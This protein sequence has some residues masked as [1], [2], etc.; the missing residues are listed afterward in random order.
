M[1]H[2]LAAVAPLLVAVRAA[3]RAAE[4]A[5]YKFEDE[6]SALFVAAQN[7]VSKV[8]EQPGQTELHSCVIAHNGNRQLEFFVTGKTVWRGFFSTSTCSYL[9]GDVHGGDL[10]SQWSLGQLSREA[11]AVVAKHDAR[12]REWG[13][14]LIELAGIFRE[15]Q[16]LECRLVA[17]N[18]C[19]GS[20]TN[21]TVP[22][23]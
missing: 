2:G 8:R 11:A 23:R 18:D 15:L 5:K 20:T 13:R 16:K 22:D 17:W 9:R 6:Q 19:V 21:L 10:S 12:C 14:K 1:K 7:A 3:L 4:V